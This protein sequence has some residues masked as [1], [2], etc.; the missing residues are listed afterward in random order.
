MR[1]SAFCVW[2][3]DA[4]IFPALLSLFERQLLDRLNRVSGTSRSDVIR[5]LLLK[6]VAQQ[7]INPDR[8]E[9]TLS[10]EPSVAILITS[11]SIR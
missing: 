5:H 4:E 8:Q 1:L 7:L 9:K 10:M 3:Y 2:R 11:R 6:E